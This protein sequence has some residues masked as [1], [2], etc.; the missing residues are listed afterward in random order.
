MFPVACTE[1]TP[2]VEAK[3]E[4]RNHSGPPSFEE[5]S[6]VPVGTPVVLD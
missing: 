4:G 1:R 3:A 2:E 5:A 6:R